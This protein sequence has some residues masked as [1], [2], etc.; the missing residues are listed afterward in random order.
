MSPASSIT[1]SPGTISLDGISCFTPF[2][3]TLA[4]GE[5]NCLRLSNERCALTCCTVPR[6]AFI[7]STS[8][9][10]M[11]LSALPENME[12]IAAIIK[13]T[14]SKSQNCPKNTSRVLFFFPSCRIFSPICLRISSTWA[15]FNPCSVTLYFCKNSCAE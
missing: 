5:D 8:N 14:T 9:I 15:S 13:I 12:M 11:V 3:I 2:L 1:I 4:L 10:T 6:T 7:I